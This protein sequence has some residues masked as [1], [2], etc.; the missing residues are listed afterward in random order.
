M[1]LAYKSQLPRKYFN[2]CPPSTC[3]F[4]TWENSALQKDIVNTSTTKQRVVLSY[5]HNGFGNQLWE[6]STAFMIAKSLKARLLIAQ[7]PDQICPGGVSPPNTWEGMEVMSRLLPKQY[8]YEELPADSYI[9]TLCENEPFLIADRPV[10]WRNRNYSAHFSS[11]IEDIVKDPTPR[12]L[13]FVGYFQVL[14]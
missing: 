2:L 12:C 6:H 4:K 9:R 13:K 8:L 5:G 14:L 1:F 3:D 11:N 10:D 7:V